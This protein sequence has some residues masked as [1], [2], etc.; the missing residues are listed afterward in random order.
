MMVEE[1]ANYFQL[2]FFVTYSWCRRDA[3]TFYKISPIILMKLNNPQL[4]C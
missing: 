4:K 2:S 1:R 3:V